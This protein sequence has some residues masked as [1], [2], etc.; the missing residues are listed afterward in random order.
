MMYFIMPIFKIKGM[1][2][3]VLMGNI[4]AL[5]VS[6]CVL[7]EFQFGFNPNLKLLINKSLYNPLE[8]FNFLDVRL[9]N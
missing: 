5:G 6:R 3:F 9:G 1:F 2:Q 4:A 8:F 7:K